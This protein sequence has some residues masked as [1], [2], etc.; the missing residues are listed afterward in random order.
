LV[1]GSVR[2]RRGTETNDPNRLRELDELARPFAIDL[3]PLE[4]AR[5]ETR[6]HPAAWRTTDRT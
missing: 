4:D 6:A 2:H 3:V 5:P 1:F